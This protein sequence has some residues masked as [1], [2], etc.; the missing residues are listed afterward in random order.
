M[1]LP[2]EPPC[3]Q[4][5]LVYLKPEKFENGEAIRPL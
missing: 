5:M 2:E 1:N 3:F 4:L